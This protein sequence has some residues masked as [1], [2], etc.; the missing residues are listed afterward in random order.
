M[1]QGSV[2]TAGFREASSCLVCNR[3]LS[4]LGR[5]LTYSTRPMASK[6]TKAWGAS[7]GPNHDFGGGLA[8]AGVAVREV[9]TISVAGAEEAGIMQVKA[10]INSF[11]L[12]P[13]GTR[14]GYT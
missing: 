7:A 9:T 12:L 1:R 3:P 10:F 6:A 5:S 2:Q 11:H 13:E 4:E 14:H 8:S